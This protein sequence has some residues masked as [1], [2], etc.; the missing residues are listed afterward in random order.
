MNYGNRIGK[1]VFEVCFY[2]HEVFIELPKGD[3]QVKMISIYIELPRLY[4]SK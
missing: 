3:R 2:I 4:Q 1:N